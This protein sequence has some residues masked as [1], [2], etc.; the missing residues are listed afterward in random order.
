MNSGATR[1]RPRSR[2]DMGIH[3]VLIMLMGLSAGC[4]SEPRTPASGVADRGPAVF[5]FGRE[6]TM[7]DIARWDVDIMPD[8]AGLP[9]GSGTV[10]DGETLYQAKC[11]ACHGPTGVEGPWDVLVGR[12]PNDEFPFGDGGRVPLTIG[13][14]WPYAPPL[15]DYIRRAMPFDAPGSL[16]DGEVYDVVALL[17]HWNDLLDPDAR[18]DAATLSQIQMP[19]RDRFV[20]DDRAGGREVR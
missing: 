20:M 8:G 19:A 13:N 12:V 1:C 5:G 6:A 3:G 11:I 10:A 18:L 9:E 15:F 14:Y 17:L 4:D 7:E 2:V 16:S